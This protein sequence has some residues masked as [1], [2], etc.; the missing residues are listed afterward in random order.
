[1]SVGTQDG[2][3]TAAA[4]TD[5]DPLLPTAAAAGASTT[6]DG[7]N[8]AGG[9]WAEYTRRAAASL[10]RRWTR[11]RLVK[12]ASSAIVGLVLLLGA[13]RILGQAGQSRAQRRARLQQRL[14][15]FTESRLEYIPTRLRVEHVLPTHDLLAD[16][17]LKDHA[18]PACRMNEF[19]QDRYNVLF[20]T[21]PHSQRTYFVGIN[22]YDSAD[23]APALIRALYS[24][25]SSLG[26]ERF[27]V[28]IY[29]NGSKDNTPHQLF[30]FAKLLRQ[31]GAGFTLV[32]DPNRQPGWE[33]GRR[34][35]GLA[36]LRNV[37]LQPLYDAPP[38]TFDQVIF[39]NDVQLCEAEILE[40][41]LQ[42][43]KQQADMSCGMDF[44]ELRIVEFEPDY[45]LLFYDTWVARDMQGLPFYEIKYPK[46]D[47]TLPSRVLPQSESRF[48]Y[49]SLVPFQVYSCFNGLTVLD[50]ALFHPPH[51]LRF[52]PSQDGTDTHSECY[53]LCSDI[54][55]T[56]SPTRADGSANPTHRR[57]KGGKPITGA[58]IQVVPRAAVGYSKLEYDRARSGINTTAFEL[59]GEEKRAYEELERVDWNSFPPKLVTTYAYGHWDEQIMVP[60]FGPDL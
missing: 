7:V 58:R 14:E 20:R 48:R 18:A 39:I 47:W 19:Q 55:Q 8:G 13:I 50:A 10:K 15:G 36:E 42:H 28:S 5:T 31:L 3:N 2:A 44:K 51:N 53:L 33:E 40:I 17:L 9:S 35:A 56:F 23:V 16:P 37:V 25:I 34:I 45:P 38:G 49:D 27:H 30:L 46:G 57:A 41:L 59:D 21:K 1:M 4:S 26:P 22:L 12:H 29:E 24:V 60:P 43:E 32:S 52:H 11:G 6:K 54:W